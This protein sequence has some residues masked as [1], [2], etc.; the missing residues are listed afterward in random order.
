MLHFPSITKADDGQYFC[1]ADN[2]VGRA[3][4]DFGTYIEVKRYKPTMK[5]ISYPIDTA[6]EYD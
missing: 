5:Y 3:E 2:G 4:R 1:T 6:T